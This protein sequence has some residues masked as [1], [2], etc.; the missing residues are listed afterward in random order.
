[1]INLIVGI[2]IYS[3]IDDVKHHTNLFFKHFY[4]DTNKLTHSLTQKVNLN[5]SLP[6]NNHVIYLQTNCNN[7]EHIFKILP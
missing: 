2:Y 7:L 6:V 1:M 4:H 3:N 5:I